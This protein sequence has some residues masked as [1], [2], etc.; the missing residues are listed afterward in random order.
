MPL[1]KPC[2]APTLA[3]DMTANNAIGAACVMLRLRPKISS[4]MAKIDP[5]APVRANTKPTNKPS[6]ILMS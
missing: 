2:A 5:P 4:G 6:K 3:A 1:F